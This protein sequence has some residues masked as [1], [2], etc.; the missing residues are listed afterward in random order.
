MGVFNHF[1]LLTVALLLIVP[2]L[3]RLAVARL[4]QALRQRTLRNTTTEA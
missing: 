2:G 3:T 4:R 1:T